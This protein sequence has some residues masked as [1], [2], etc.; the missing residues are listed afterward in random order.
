MKLTIDSLGFTRPMQLAQSTRDAHDAM[1]AAREAFAKITGVIFTRETNARTASVYDGDNQFLGYIC[2]PSGSGPFPKLYRRALSAEFIAARTTIAAHISNLRERNN[3]PA[4]EQAVNGS[5]DSRISYGVNAIERM[6]KC[7]FVP[8]SFRYEKAIGLEM[9]GFSLLDHAEL[10]DALPHWCRVAGDGSIRVNQS[11]EIA[12]EIKAVF[13]R[14]ALEPRLYRL[15]SILKSLGLKCNKSCGLHVHFDMR[16]KDRS[17]VLKIAKR[18]NKWLEALQQLVPA[19]RRDQTYCK[20]GVSNTGADRYR[21]VN[22]AAFDKYQTLEIR[23]HSAT[24]DYAKILSWIR[25]CELIMAIRYN[26]KDAD[27]VGTLGQL[28]LMD[29]EASYWRAR[30]KALNPAQY[31]NQD[32]SQTEASE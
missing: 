7:H 9:E 5:V 20:F 32:G 31:N 10:S 26:P 25:L 1:N 18:A 22:F 4:S 11:E 16:G 13:P 30:H 24:F 29:Y 19:S 28:P 21:A 2:I 23:L 15:A 8:Q 6:K 14:S 17:E 27:C 12:A 3:R